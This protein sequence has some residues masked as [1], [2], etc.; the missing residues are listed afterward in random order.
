[1]NVSYYHIILLI[2][3]IQLH[4]EKKRN[5]YRKW[6]FYIIDTHHTQESKTRTILKII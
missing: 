4:E 6:T 2:I 1:M 3:K 5:D